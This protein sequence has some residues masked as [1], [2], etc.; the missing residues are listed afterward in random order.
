MKKLISIFAVAAMLLCAFTAAASAAELQNYCKKATILEVSAAVD[1]NPATNAIDG[2]GDTFW[3]SGK[4]DTANIVVDLGKPMPV[5]YI[6]IIWGDDYAVSY[7]LGTSSNAEAVA[8]TDVYESKGGTDE[9]T[10]DSITTM[11]CLNFE[12]YKPSGSNGCAI[13]EIVIRRT[14]DATEAAA[15]GYPSSG[16]T[17]PDG[18]FIIKGE[19]IGLEEGW[20]GNADAGRDAAFDGDINT[21]FD[22][23]GT[24]DGYAGVDAGEQYTLTY[25]VIHPR[26]GQLPRFDGAEINGSNDGENW[27][28]IWISEGEA[29]EW[30]WQEISADKFKI[31]NPTFRY[32][33]YFNEY[34]HGDVGE[35]ELYG[36]PVDGTVDWLPVEEE[37]II[38]EEAPAEAAPAEAAPAEAAPAAAPAAPAASPQTSDALSLVVAAAVMALGSAVIVSKKRK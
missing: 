37:I 16:V 2:K 20:G 3:A 38:E 5:G 29:E 4:V 33:R 15:S 9:I 24:G 36:V 25:I 14:A 32:F 6:Q 22:P 13:K 27:E 34:T 28:L 30:T 23:L 18:S 11:R 21:Y 35:V 17:P 8:G 1:A 26:D 7:G 10:L 19:L 12:L 31:Q